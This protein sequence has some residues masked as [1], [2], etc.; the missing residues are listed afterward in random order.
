MNLFHA[1]TF[2]HAAGPSAMASHTFTSADDSGVH[3]SV[4]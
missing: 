2:R 3:E 1:R 4:L